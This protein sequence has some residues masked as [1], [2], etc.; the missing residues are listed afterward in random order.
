MISA[1]GYTYTAT[2]QARGICYIRWRA[3][4]AC[5]LE[6]VEITNN[7]RAGVLLSI[8]IGDS[9]AVGALIALE[10][11]QTMIVGESVHWDGAQA[12]NVDQE[13]VGVCQAG[14]VADELKVLVKVR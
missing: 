13:V 1:T 6:A 8:G 7:T 9:G 12:M 11:R 5:V 3:E 14:I 2:D 10:Q 4:R